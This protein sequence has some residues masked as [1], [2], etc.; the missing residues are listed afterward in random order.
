MSG[1][2]D[3]LEALEATYRMN[4]IDSIPLDELR[5]LYRKAID[6][7]M[8][9]KIDHEEITR[10]SHFTITEHLL[11]YSHLNPITRTILHCEEKTNIVVIVEKMEI[12]EDYSNQLRQKQR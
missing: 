2:D 1:E 4:E 10:K 9:S 7:L 6:A 3:S 5:D 12:E 11:P 8:Q